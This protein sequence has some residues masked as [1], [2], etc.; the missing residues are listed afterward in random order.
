MN[1]YIKLFLVFAKIGTFSF[2]GGNAIL[3]L[4][5]KEAVTNYHWISAREFTELIAI[6]QATPG[7]IAVNG[8]TYI[9]CR[10]GG[11][12][13][14]LVATLGVVLPTFIIMVI[15]TKFFLKFKDNKYV[16][17]AFI[18]LKPATVGLVAAAAVLVSYGTFIDYK[19]ILIAVVAFIALY[20]YK[21]DPILLTI[22][23]GIAGLILYK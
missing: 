13:G 21:A 18:V 2:G 4:L 12:L 14:S 3:P 1:I 9:G 8:A 5:R 16:E 19:S 23:A 11:A 22:A 10:A 15:F 7:P 20:K 6:S 17:D